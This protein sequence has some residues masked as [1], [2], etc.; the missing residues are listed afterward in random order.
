VNGS[1]L[2]ND[3]DEDASSPGITL[4]NLPRPHY[5]K[6]PSLLSDLEMLKRLYFGSSDSLYSP[7]DNQEPRNWRL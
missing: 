1:D 6:D 5:L 7:R 3:M 2:R 4:P